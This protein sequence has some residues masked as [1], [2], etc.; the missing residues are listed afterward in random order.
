MSVRERAQ[1]QPIVEAGKA[2]AYTLR[3]RSTLEENR[4]DFEAGYWAHGGMMKACARLCEFYRST[5][6]RGS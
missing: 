2:F 3:H 4:I 6:S 5:L 1:I